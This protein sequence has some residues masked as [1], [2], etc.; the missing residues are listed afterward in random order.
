MGKTKMPRNLDRGHA[1][2]YTVRVPLWPYL[3]TPISAVAAYPITWGAHHWY[4]ASP[5]TG[6]G[7]TFADL[8]VVGFV[9]WAAR[10]RGAVMRAMSTGLAAAGSVWTTIGVIESPIS[11]EMFGAWFV[12][13]LVGSVVV[14]AQR[15][16]R[17]GSTEQQQDDPTVMGGL[18]DRVKELKDVRFGQAKVI[19]GKVTSEVTMPP[20]AVFGSLPQD[21]IASLADVAAPAV[22]TIPDPDSER[23]GRIEVVPVDQLRTPPPW[24]G[25]SRPG[26]SIAEP[27]LLGVVEDAEPLE[28]VLPGDPAVNRNATHVGVVG[29]SGAG[30]TEVILRIVEEVSTRHDAEYWMGDVRKADQLP[31]WARQRAARF[32]ATEPDIDVMLDDLLDEVP[33]R[34]KQMGSHGHKQWT[35]GCDQCPKYRVVILDEAAQVAAG[36]KVFVDLS[37]SLRSVGVTLLVGLQRATW[38]RFPTSARANIGTWLCLGV[39][40]DEDAEAALSEETLA[41]GAKPWRWKAFFPGYLYAEV[42]GVDPARWSLRC[43]SFAPPPSEDVRAQAVAAVTGQPVATVAATATVDPKPERPVAP[44]RNRDLVPDAGGQAVDADMTALVDGDPPDDVDPEQPIVVPAGM[45]RVSFGEPKEQMRPEEAREEMKTYL[46]DL[47]DAGTRMVKPGHLADVLARTGMSGSWL[48]KMISS[49]QLGG[50]PLLKKVEHG[51]Y[52]IQLPEH[53]HVG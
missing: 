25:P 20:G 30:K 31:G 15:I 49:F 13:T 4:G 36:N 53:E 2:V 10:P 51:W 1:S 40:R 33:V 23:R 43:R 28:L 38:D 48:N 18:L 44:N 42:P 17:N 32:A 26:G 9:W 41:A 3:V 29:M 5:W 50:A 52:E 24:P 12:G 47:A 21:E 35:V 39:Q 7:L 6:V 37:E 8:T 19:G 34:A 16:L 22:R 14:A 45:P 11:K 46:I 27:L